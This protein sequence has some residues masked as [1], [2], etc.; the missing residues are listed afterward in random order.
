MFR[1]KLESHLESLGREWL[2]INETHP[3]YNSKLPQVDPEPPQ[4]STHRRGRSGRWSG[5]NTQVIQE[6][7]EI[8]PWYD[9]PG[10]AKIRQRILVPLGPEGRRHQDQGA[11]DHRDLRPLQIEFHGTLRFSKTIMPERPFRFQ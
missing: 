3:N 8:R 1:Y 2:I 7:L 9:D 4:R 6:G 5:L 11:Q 10:L